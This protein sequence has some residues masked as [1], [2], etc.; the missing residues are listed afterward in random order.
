VGNATVL[1]GLTGVVGCV[2]V[3]MKD[4]FKVFTNGLKVFILAPS[5]LL[6][7]RRHDMGTLKIG[8]KVATKAT[9]AF[10]G[11]PGVASETGKV[12]RARAGESAPDGWAL[13]RF[14]AD[15]GR[16]CVHESQLVE[17]LS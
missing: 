1:W 17:V 8:T 10:A 13:V 16:L 2:L 14:D 15:G 7:N 11:F 3:M 9:P 4:R 6:N 12:V 5:S